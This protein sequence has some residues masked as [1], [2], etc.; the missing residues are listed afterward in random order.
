MK[1]FI[2]KILA[3]FI[4][5]TSLVDADYVVSTVN[6]VGSSWENDAACIYLDSGDVVKL[7]MTTHKGSTELSMALTAKV[8]SKSLRVYFHDDPNLLGGC[9]TGTT[10]TR[11]GVIQLQ[12]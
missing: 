4:L 5:S 3:L 10:I 8:S 11:H 7:D 9:S 2:F 1:H 12:D 6:K